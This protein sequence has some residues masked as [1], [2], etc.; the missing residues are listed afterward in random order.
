MPVGAN[1]AKQVEQ[2]LGFPQH[3]ENLE[4]LEKWE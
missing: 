4:N 1:Q 3:L 2:N